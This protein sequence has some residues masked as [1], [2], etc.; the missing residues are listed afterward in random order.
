MKD[1]FLSESKHM[2]KLKFEELFKQSITESGIKPPK[3]VVTDG[4]FHRFSTNDKTGD[5][6]G[7]YVLKDLGFVVMG[8]FGC[9]RSGVKGNW[10]SVDKTNLSKEQIQNLKKQQKQAHEL[11]ESKKLEEQKQASAKAERIWKEADPANL[12]HP[13]LVKKGLK[14]SNIK[15]SKRDDLDVLLVPLKDVEGKLWSLQRI[16]PDGNKLFLKKGRVQGLFHT[17][18]SPTTERIVAE[19]YATAA[20]IYESTGLCIHVAFNCSNLK[21]VAKEIRKLHP[22]S[23]LIIAADD[24]WKTE[25]NPGIKHARE[26]AIASDAKLAVPVFS[27]GNRLEKDTDFNDLFL[28]EGTIAVKNCIEAAKYPADEDS[29]KQNPNKDESD[30]KSSQATALVEIAENSCELFTDENSDPYVHIPTDGHLETYRVDSTVFRTWLSK[31]YWQEIDRVANDTSVRSAITTLGGLAQFSN[32]QKKVFLRVGESEDRFF[33]DLADESWGCIEITKSGW[34]LKDDSPVT[35]L[36]TSSM[37]SLPLPKEPGEINLIWKHVNISEDDRLLML[38][39]LL[40]CLRPNTPDPLLELCGEQGTGKSVTHNNIR[41]LIDPNKVNLRSAPDKLDD[42]LVSAVHSHLVSIENASKLSSQMQDRLC[43]LATGGGFA[44]RSLYTNSEETA[45]AIKRPVII[46]G[47]TGVVTRADLLDR[48][49]SLE[50]PVLKERRTASQMLQDFENDRPYI[51]AGILDTFSKVL[52]KLPDIKIDPQK[53]PRMGDF[54]LI[55][56]ALYQVMGRPAG[57]FLTEFSENKKSGVRRTLDTSPVGQAI[58]SLMESP[59]TND[60]F[61]GTIKQ[62]L[63]D[64]EDHKPDKDVWVKSARGLGDALRR[65]GPALRTIGIDVQVD[66]KPRR[67][68]YHVCI[69][70]NTESGIADH[71][72]D[73]HEREHCERCEQVS[74]SKQ[75]QELEEEVF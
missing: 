48:T 22:D 65:L 42:L 55:G 3:N 44:V 51:L 61:E 64:L 16:Y 12:R 29:K 18:G 30:Q 62:L 17:I 14:Q 34:K 67:D 7:W 26:A 20:S 2:N 43:S 39:W 40:E 21:A 11:A 75:T 72:S 53:L 5:K 4:E 9:F 37:R 31:C 13:Y 36:R 10:K 58:Q 35:F 56:E 57:S 50:L 54:A 73:S 38:S 32:V 47:I 33:L 27:E 6:A 25:G 24:D 71:S 15:Q 8:S 1:L 49:L 69:T 28:S 52:S 41:Q 63:E 74:E 45:L 59:E 68:G 23:E 60:Q 46:N 70:R 19:G 66:K